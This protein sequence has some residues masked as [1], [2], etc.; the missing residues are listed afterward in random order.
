MDISDNTATDLQD[1]IIAPVFFE[2]YR[3]QVTERM[4]DEQYMRLLS[5]YTSSAFQDFESFLRTQTDLVEDDIKRVLDEYNS[6]FITYDLEPV[7]YTFKYISEAL[8]N[9]LQREYPGPSN[10]IVTEFDDIGRKTK[11]VVNFGF[12]AIRFDENSFFR[13]IVGFT[14]SWVYK[15]YNEYTIQNL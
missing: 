11:L 5:F 4:K 12:I 3:E 7:I 10:A 13:T 6:S 15:H 9:I 14:P 1:D 2:E 8:F